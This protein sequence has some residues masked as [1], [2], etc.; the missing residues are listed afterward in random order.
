[1]GTDRWTAVMPDISIGYYKAEDL[2]VQ[3]PKAILKS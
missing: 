1:M 3:A 2:P